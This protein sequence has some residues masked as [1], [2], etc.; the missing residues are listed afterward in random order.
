MSSLTSPLFPPSFIPHS[1]L[2]E[3]AAHLNATV[4]FGQGSI[5]DKEC[6]EVIIGSQ[7]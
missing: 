5:L 3:I 7:R 6:S 4:L 2:D 1:R